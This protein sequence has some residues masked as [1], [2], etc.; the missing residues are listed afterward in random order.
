MP[1]GGLELQ[2]PELFEQVLATPFLAGQTLQPGDLQPQKELRKLKSIWGV[3]VDY[4]FHVRVV[5][6]AGFAGVLQPEFPGGAIDRFR[7]EGASGKFGTIDPYNVNGATG[8]QY[9]NAFLSFAPSFALVSVNGA[10]YV[11]ALGPG[12]TRPANP[13]A[14]ATTTDY[15]VVIRYIVPFVPLDV[16]DPIQ[17]AAFLLD[18]RDWNPLILHMFLADQSGLF[19]VKANGTFTFGALQGNFPASPGAAGSGAAVAPTGSPRADVHLIRP[20]LRR[21]GLENSK[22]VGSRLVVRTFQPITSTLQ[23]AVLTDGLIARLTVTGGNKARSLRIL[24][25]TG[26]KTADTPTSGVGGSFGGLSDAIISQPFEKRAGVRIRQP[27]TNSALKGYFN[28]Q[29]ATNLPIGYNV[30]DHLEQGDTRTSFNTSELSKDEFTI[31]G[32][33][34]TIAANQI[35]EVVEERYLI[36]A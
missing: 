36:A 5:G 11:S 7:V 31:E 29:K 8:F 20:N 22:A 4:S 19:D 18:G 21:V 3:M 24:V 2:G 27:W 25:K 14:G 32:A 10:A 6:V 1:F 28:I 34:P 15:D 26:T 9:H 13:T 35:G 23:A 33:V 12:N 16:L 17:Q 30:I